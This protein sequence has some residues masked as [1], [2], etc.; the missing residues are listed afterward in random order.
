MAE[1]KI[2]EIRE[3]LSEREESFEKWRNTIGLF[4]GP[5]L[6]IVVYSLD[7]PALSPKAHI[8]AAVLAW[9]V[10]WWICEPIPW[11]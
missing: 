3:T 9:T 4:L 7:M 2:T 6:A 8:L 11:Q 5:L 1:E 10:A